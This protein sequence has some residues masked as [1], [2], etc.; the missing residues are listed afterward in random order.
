VGLGLARGGAG[1]GEVP[2]SQPLGQP[3]GADGGHQAMEVL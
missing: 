2:G 1:E 3:S